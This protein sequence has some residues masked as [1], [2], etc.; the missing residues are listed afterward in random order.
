MEFFLVFR[1]C[2][3]F[4]VFSEKFGI[5]FGMY[6]VYYIGFVRRVFVRKFDRVLS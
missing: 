1:V 5:Y 2:W 4:F 6:F 3:V